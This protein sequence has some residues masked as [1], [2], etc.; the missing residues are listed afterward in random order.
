[1]LPRERDG[2]H[3]SPEPLDVESLACTDFQP[4]YL[5]DE[6]K[7]RWPYCLHLEGHIRAHASFVRPGP[8]PELASSGCRL[9]PLCIWE[10]IERAAV[11]LALQTAI[12][13]STFGEEKTPHG[14][15]RSA[16]PIGSSPAAFLPA[17]VGDQIVPTRSSSCCRSADG[18][19][20]EEQLY[21]VSTHQCNQ[22]H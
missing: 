7:I 6:I 22:Q 4:N 12:I 20:T 14:M 2:S 3:L 15:T 10:R 8:A 19:C 1:M 21:L 18:F 13:H 5:T 17:A 9:M 16:L 11:Q